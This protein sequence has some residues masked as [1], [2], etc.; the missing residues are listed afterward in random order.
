MFAWAALSWSLAQAQ[1]STRHQVFGLTVG[2]A[3]IQ[4]KDEF[5]S[6]YSYTGTN[7]QLG[8]AYVRTTPHHR[9]EFAVDLLSGGLQS[10]VSP[11]G[12]GQTG[13]LSYD[14]FF[15]NR[16]LGNKLDGRLGLGL[17][18]I[19]SRVTYLPDV[20]L[21]VSYLTM[22]GFLSVDGRL[23]FQVSSRS[24]LV[25][26]ATVSTVGVMYR[27]DFEINGNSST[28]AAF[29][30]NSLFYTVNVAY[31]YQVS[32][33][34]DLMVGYRYQYFTYSQP[35]PIYLSH[36]SLYFGVRLKG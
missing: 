27:P 11:R 14:Y 13:Y 20:E 17:H 23:R 32:P 7:L 5:Q 30:G 35:R 36:H 10:S 29:W 33:K 28:S 18:A 9:H 25:L 3:G 19:A 6:P 21:P 2:M 24:A 22:G 12:Q 34:L 31:V 8:L 4:M 15:R 26:S 16:S 1:D